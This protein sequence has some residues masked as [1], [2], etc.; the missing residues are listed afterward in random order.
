M[1][2]MTLKSG[3]TYLFT[4][5]YSNYQNKVG[6]DSITI[7]TLPLN[8]DNISEGE[9]LFLKHYFESFILNKIGPHIRMTQ[10]FYQTF[11]PDEKITFRA[12]LSYIV[13]DA[14]E[15]TIKYLKN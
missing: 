11:H 15:G 5:T 1:P 8:S 4:V 12:E 13:C 2:A 3:K 10:P 9:L 6:T 14:T 7:T